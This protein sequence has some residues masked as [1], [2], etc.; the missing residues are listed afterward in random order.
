MD[1]FV[2]CHGLIKDNMVRTKSGFTNN[3]F[4]IDKRFYAQESS[5]GWILF[6]WN[7]EHTCVYS[8]GAETFIQL[9]KSGKMVYSKKYQPIENPKF[10]SA[11]L[12]LF[13]QQD[14]FSE[15]KYEDFSKL[16]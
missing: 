3:L 13:T 5:D 14:F 9:W 10:L 8:Y 11:C 4:K 7:D 6:N 12:E 15:G 2:K 16:N 1:N